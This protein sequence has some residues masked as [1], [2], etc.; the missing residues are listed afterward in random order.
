MIV[1]ITGSTGFVGGEVLTRLSKRTDIEKIFCLVRAKNQEEG[2]ARLQKVFALHGDH[3]S[4]EKIIPVVLDLTAENFAEVMASTPGLSSVNLIIHS[5]ANTSFSRI[6]DDAIEK[7]NIRGLENILSWAQTLKSLKTFTYI[8]TATICGAD[9]RNTMIYEQDSPNKQ[10]SHLVKYTYSK[11]MGEL[12]IEKYLPWDKVLILR[13]SIIM[14]DSSNPV[15][16]SQVIL[17]TLAT[18]NFLRLFPVSENVKLD[19]IPID[20]AAKA[21]E[22]LTF[23]TSRKHSVYHISS[24]PNGA[25]TPIQLTEA[26]APFFPGKL[27]FKFVDISML[28]QMKHWA[29]KRLDSSSELFK[30][31]EYLDY[32]E[33]EFNFDRSK[34]RILFAGLEPYLY[35]MELGQIFDN[36]RLLSET[37][38][39]QSPP[40][41]QYIPG[42]VKFMG[43]IDIFE[44][45]LNP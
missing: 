29:R 10:T 14:G 24:G 22:D 16:R 13:P 19:I 36:T 34:L 3:F 26:I 27:P 8:G 45:A 33:K 6:F 42:C 44:G 7:I 25:T 1:F 23:A 40:A 38:T 2:T 35:F 37:D 11:M 30:H 31:Q 15:P 9:R 5:A 43:G 12:T 39:G 18:S 41:H 4:K 21:I 28:G 32:W 20:Y 17:W